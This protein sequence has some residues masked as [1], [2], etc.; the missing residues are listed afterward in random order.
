M[1]RIR[2]FHIV[3]TLLGMGGME[4]GVVNL[5]RRLDPDRYEH[6]VCVLRR[7]GTLA[8]L[9]PPD[10]ARVVCLG[11]TGSGMRFQTG[12]LARQIKAAKPHI[13]HS[14]NWGT[15][16]GVFASRCVGCL[17]TVYSEHGMELSSP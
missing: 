9:I 4:K 12:I 11:E 8:D 16:E 14:R 10:H 3:D 2:V 1:M 13:V 15:I 17:A 5:I 6:V 7:L